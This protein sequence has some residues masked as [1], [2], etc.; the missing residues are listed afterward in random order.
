MTPAQQAALV[1]WLRAQA[2]AIAPGQVQPPAPSPPAPAPT[3][4]P[5]APAGRLLESV[6]ATM[7]PGEWRQV[8]TT[9]PPEFSNFQ[10]FQYVKA[11]PPATGGADGMGWTERIVER[12]GRL[13][14]VLMRDSFQQY[15]ATMTADGAWSRSPLDGLPNVGERRPFNRL[16]EAHGYALFSESDGKTS[17][18]DFYRT[19]L[20]NPGAWERFG[21]PVGN[22]QFD[23]VGN[24]A[25]CY[26]PD[27]DRYFHFCPGG[28][29]YSA[30]HADLEAATPNCW[31]RHD[32]NIPQAQSPTGFAGTILWNPVKR[33][34]WA[35]GGQTFGTAPD[36]SMYSLSISGP[37]EQTVLH[38]PAR[39]PDGT[40][41]GA[42]TSGSS[43]FITDRRDGSVFMLYRDHKLYR[44][45]DG[46]VWD[47]YEDLTAL[48]PW[49][50]YEQYIPW[51]HLGAHDDVIVCV[52]HMRGVWLHR[53]KA[54]S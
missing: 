29:I 33:Q 44:S 16:I 1:A 28:K 7:Q 25:S 22:D 21:V 27:W 51:T 13:L 20:D 9:L 3:P 49:G 46:E 48:K 8:S 2:E 11:I 53:L 43:R 54:L 17:I 19:P 6:A 39:L 5:P 32:E 26:S 36:L 14:T 23:T 18:G 24:F 41:L 10:G 4:A 42:I 38:G 37:T 12:D 50:N 47:L 30:S 34:V 45:V 35:A 40:V 31:I 52:S 15:L